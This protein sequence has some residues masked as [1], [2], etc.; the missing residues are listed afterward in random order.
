MKRVSHQK[1]TPK[2]PLG[3]LKLPLTINSRIPGKK[4]EL[5]SE[6]SQHQN[7]DKPHGICGPNFSGQ[8][9]VSSPHDTDTLFTEQKD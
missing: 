3:V 4:I 9:V 5:T 6:Q 8:P 1:N 7:H 2:L